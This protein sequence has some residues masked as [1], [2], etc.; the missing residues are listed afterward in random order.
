M[1]WIACNEGQDE[2]KQLENKKIKI[3]WKRGLYSLL[4]FNECIAVKDIL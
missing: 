2:S 1:W 3:R 4:H